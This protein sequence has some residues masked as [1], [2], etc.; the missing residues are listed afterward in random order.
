MAS[1]P[2]GT[3]VYPFMAL[4]KREGRAWSPDVRD[5]AMRVAAGAGCQCWEDFAATPAEVESTAASARKIGLSTPSF[6]ANARLHDESASS[7]V[8][9]MSLVAQAAAGVG[10]EFF[11][12]NAEPIEWGKPLDKDDA[13]L[14]RQAGA[15]AD[16]DA[17][18][19]DA[20]VTLAYHTH[21]IEMRHAA[22]ELHHM[23]VNVPAMGF[24]FDPEWVFAGA[25]KSNLAT[26]DI[27][28]LYG[29]R[30]KVLHFRDRRDDRWAETFGGG[31]IDF[32]SLLK[33]LPGFDGPLLL[34]QAAD[35][36]TPLE[37]DP[38]TALRTS[39][40]HLREL[41]A[42]LGDDAGSGR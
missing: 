21:D 12:V 5:E 13:Q 8:A 26:Q 4:A 14:A 34:E 2:I 18:C 15:F 36:D 31:E 32:E 7:V 10:A 37:L 42:V 38:A 33:L 24:C 30:V 6:Y 20:G 29:D 40:G 11:T 9:S 17:A 22:R 41:S 35:P 19:R 27:A 23:L 3:G 1:L 25:G 28:R 39:V 16:L